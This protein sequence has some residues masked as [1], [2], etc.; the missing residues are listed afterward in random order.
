MHVSGRQHEG[1][2]L[3]Q[4]VG[5]LVIKATNEDAE[6]VHAHLPWSAGLRYGT[7]RRWGLVSTSVAR[8]ALSQLFFAPTQ[9]VDSGYAEKANDLLVAQ[10]QK[11]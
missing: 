8:A 5:V 11:G 4:L 10:R 3:G 9:Y 2:D 1:R 7:M 6:A